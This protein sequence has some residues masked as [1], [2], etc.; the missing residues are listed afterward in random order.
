MT[1]VRWVQ[2]SVR[3]RFINEMRSLWLHDLLDNNRVA[4]VYNGQVWCGYGRVDRGA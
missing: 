2:Q 4:C 3:E 1:V